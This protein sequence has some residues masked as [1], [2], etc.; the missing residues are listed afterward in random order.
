M[1]IPCFLQVFQPGEFSG[2]IHCYLGDP[3]LREIVL[4]VSGTVKSAN[5]P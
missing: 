5:N 1:D 2:Q 4:K 3:Y